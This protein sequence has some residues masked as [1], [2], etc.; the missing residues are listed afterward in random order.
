MNLSDR[1]ARLTDFEAIRLA[2][3]FGEQILQACY[4]EPS[5]LE[6][7]VDARLTSDERVAALL[8]LTPEQGTERLDGDETI[9]VA[10]AM[11]ALWSSDAAIAPALD[12]A[13]N[14]WRDDA[15]EADV[16]MS[17]GFVV[18]LWICVASTGF[19]GRIGSLVHNSQERGSA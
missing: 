11:L 2:Q 4:V 18:S 9:A 3:Y 5:V 1:I 17:V 14:G 16:I 13:L 12:D 19:K 6:Q 15:L 8:A 10:R 7:G